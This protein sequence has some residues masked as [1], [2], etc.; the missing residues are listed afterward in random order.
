MRAQ[1]IVGAAAQ[2]PGKPAVGSG[3]GWHANLC[4][5]LTEMRRPELR[6]AKRIQL[7]FVRPR[8]GKKDSRPD[9]NALE[10][11]LCRNS[12]DLSEGEISE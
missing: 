7:V 3:K 9:E 6:L 11:A 10:M 5:V 1:Q 4:Y 2:H 12:P 8:G